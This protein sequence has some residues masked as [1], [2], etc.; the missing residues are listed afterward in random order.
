MQTALNARLVDSHL[1]LK[2]VIS[3]IPNIQAKKSRIP[4]LNSGESRFP[5]RCKIRFPVKISCVFPNPTPYFGQI[6]DPEN[7]L[8]D[9][10]RCP[11]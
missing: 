10:E 7:T 5:G 3:R 6:L 8:L 11:I 1:P 2:R 4:C 9:P